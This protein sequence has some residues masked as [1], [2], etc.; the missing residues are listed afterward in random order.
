MRRQGNSTVV[1]PGVQELQEVLGAS[2]VGEMISSE[3][4]FWSEI[5]GIAGFRLD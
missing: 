2:R 4:V 1:L 5:V 3:Q